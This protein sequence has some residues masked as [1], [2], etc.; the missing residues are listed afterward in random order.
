MIIKQSTLYLL[1][2][3]SANLHDSIFKLMTFDYAEK[4]L[5]I[6]V[7]SDNSNDRKRVIKFINVIGFNMVSCDFWGKSPHILDWSVHL[8]QDQSIIKKL[9]E[10]KEC[11]HYRFSRLEDE[12]TYLESVILFTSGDR[13]TIACEQ[14]ELEDDIGGVLSNTK[15]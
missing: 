11:Y 9:I 6:E 13:L 5:Y 7:V 4:C 8:T 3:S 12:Q 10:E 15:E 14:I 2:T 1:N